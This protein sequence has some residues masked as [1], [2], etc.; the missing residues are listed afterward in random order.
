MNT[1]KTGPTILVVD[2]EPDLRAILMATLTMKGFRALSAESGRAAL[3]I[4][5]ATSIDVI[6]SDV[7]MPDGDGLQLLKDVQA[8]KLPI[9]FI[10]MTGYADFS[11]DEARSLGANYFISKPFNIDDIINAVQ[12]VSQP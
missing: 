3:K 12:K 10:F 7:R 6:L 4:I 5:D 2:D 9:P 8:R 1:S 11:A